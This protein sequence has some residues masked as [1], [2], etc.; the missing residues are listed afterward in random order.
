MLPTEAARSSWTDI[1]TAE[2]R[3]TRRLPASLDIF[4]SRERPGPRSV[5]HLWPPESL[6]AAHPF[7]SEEV[8]SHG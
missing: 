2:I 6:Q 3:A 5:V 4:R 7:F 1:C 8:R